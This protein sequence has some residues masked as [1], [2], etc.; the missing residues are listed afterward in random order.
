MY[1]PY[2]ITYIAAGFVIS[3][4]GILWAY[5]NGQFKDQQRARYLPLENESTIPDVKLSRSSRYEI[6][7]LLFLVFAGLTASVAILAFSLLNS[8]RVG[9]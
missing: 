4:L 6:Y 2:F 3:L 7:G 9:G 8:G 5:K 1:Y